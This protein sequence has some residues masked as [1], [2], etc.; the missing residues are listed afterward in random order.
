MK[1]Q[2]NFSEE[3]DEMEVSNSSDIKFR[4]M[5]IRIL[6]TWKRQKI[7]KDESEIKN[8]ISKIN[9]TLE[10]IKSRLDEA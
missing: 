10:G 1:K 3:L 8:A 6:K 9:N 2:E 4:V 5:I 7:K